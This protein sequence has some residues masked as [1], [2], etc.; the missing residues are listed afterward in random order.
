RLAEAWQSLWDNFVDPRESLWDDGSTWVGLGAAPANSPLAKSPYVNE[1]QLR[2]I[3]D[4]CRAL[5]VENEF[6]ING[7]ENR[8]SYLVGAGHTYRAAARKGHDAP[9]ELCRAAQLVLDEFV[10]EN[11]WH[12]R[13]QEIV[14][15][16]DRD[17]EVFLRFFVVDDG[18]L[19][20]RF[21]EPGQVS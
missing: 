17:G 2:D 19:R 8:V 11:C 6:A 1:A 3:R 20:L 4:Q 13:Q 12:R 21:V 7:H 5:A 18:R 16:A 15:R 10:D 9:V 14:R